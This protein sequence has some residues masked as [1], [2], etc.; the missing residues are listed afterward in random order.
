[1]LAGVSDEMHR[2]DGISGRRSIEVAAMRPGAQRTDDSLAAGTAERSERPRST[3]AMIF[4]VPS[5]HAS[6]RRDI[7]HIYNPVEFRVELIS[8]LPGLDMDQ[9]PLASRSKT[10]HA[11][12]VL[13][14]QTRRNDGCERLAHRLMSKTMIVGLD[15]GVIAN[16]RA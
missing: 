9:I 13:A 7:V 16:R 15:E 4:K 2:R 11:L 3:V 6:Q 8:P 1:V 10:D 5:D 12:D 14:S